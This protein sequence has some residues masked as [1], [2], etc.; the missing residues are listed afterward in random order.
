MPR[1]G[2]T[3]SPGGMGLP[4][5]THMLSAKFVFLGCG[6][7]ARANDMTITSAPVSG[8][9]PSGS[10]R[11]G[12]PFWDFSLKIYSSPAVQKACVDLQ[13]GSGVDV[14]VLLYMLWHGSQGRRLSDQDAKAVLD[15][16]EGWRIDVVVPLRTARRNLK[17]PPPALDPP[18][19]EALRAIVKKAELEAERLQQSALFTLKLPSGATSGAVAVRAAAEANVAAYAEALGRPLAEKPLSVMLEA[20]D[21]LV[22]S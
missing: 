20:L 5:P 12:N 7:S 10:G 16:V 3:E 2:A 1:D 19:A 8:T 9:T 17:T 14:N 13:D 11:A 18:A 6:S 21:S 4:A 15:A 22:T